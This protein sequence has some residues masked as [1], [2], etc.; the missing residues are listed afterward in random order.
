M[1]LKVVWSCLEHHQHETEKEAEA[2]ILKT[3]RRISLTA[4]DLM[5]PRCWKMEYKPLE[6]W[7]SDGFRQWLREQELTEIKTTT[8]GKYECYHGL[9]IVIRTIVPA[10]DVWLI[11]QEPFQ[12][13]PADE[14]IRVG[15]W[16]E[17]V[18][19]IKDLGKA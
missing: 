17:K 4:L 9:L 18:Q 6:I 3:R 13:L 5:I 10:Y 12:I 2:C 11:A 19:K 14:A 16:D 1:E 8:S 15:L 7:M